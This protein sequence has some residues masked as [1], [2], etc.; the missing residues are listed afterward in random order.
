[1][2]LSHGLTTAYENIGAW[3]ERKRETGVNRK[4][5]L[6]MQHSREKETN[7]KY[8][9]IGQKEIISVS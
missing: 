4:M 6:H 5:K 2:N 8:S 1:M 3:S 7:T 9:F